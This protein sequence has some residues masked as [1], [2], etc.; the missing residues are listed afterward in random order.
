[1]DVKAIVEDLKF[2]S[3]VFFYISSWSGSTMDADVSALPSMR[4]PFLYLQNC[5]HS[6][7]V[8]LNQIFRWLNFSSVLPR[9]LIFHFLHTSQHINPTQITKRQR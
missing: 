7:T 4:G 6:A 5:V 3:V 8:H 1:M 9:P 2:F